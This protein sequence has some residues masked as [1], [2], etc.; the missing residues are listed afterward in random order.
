M[1]GTHTLQMQQI[2]FESHYSAKRDIIHQ[3]HTF[4]CF[5]KLEKLLEGE[6]LGICDA[7]LCDRT[8]KS[9]NADSALHLLTILYSAEAVGKMHFDHCD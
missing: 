5:I 2:A 1:H 9:H 8:P 3:C 4:R 7:G 6:K